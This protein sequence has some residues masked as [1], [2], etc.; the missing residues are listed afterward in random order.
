MRAIAHTLVA[1]AIAGVGLVVAGGSPAGAQ[2]G[3][4]VTSTT[5]NVG[6][7]AAVENFVG[8]PY[9]SGFDGVQAY[10]NY[11]NAKGGV[12]GRKFKLVARLD[13]Q[14]SPSTD[15]VQA[16]SL[17]EE[18]H[19]FAILP[20]VVDNFTAGSY[21]ARSGVPTFGWN[22]NAQWASGYP[23]PGAN[24][25][26]D[27]VVVP[28]ATGTPCSGT[29]APNLFGEK[30]SFL[31]FTCPNAASSYI[32]SQLG[33]KNVAILAYS[34]PQSA[35]CATGTEVGFR[36]YGFNVVVNDHSLPPGFSDIG[37]DIDAMRAGNVKF[38]GSCMDI[39]GNVRAAA[40]LRRAGLTDV[41][42]FAPQGYDPGTLKKY[43]AALNGFI[44]L[45]DFVPFEAANESPGM[46]L[47]LKQMAALGRPVNE[48][49]L[50]GWI[51][52]D[53]LYKG[54]KAAGPNF[55]QASVVQAVNQINGYT[56]DGIRT[57][58]NWSF[59]GHR[60][61]TEGCGA[62]IAVQNGKFVPVFGRPGQPFICSQTNPLP[63]KAD[64]S[65]I[66]FRPPKPGEQLPSTATVP[67]TSPATP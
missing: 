51:D 14:D 61:G 25:P 46:K 27:C 19:V 31:C 7:M 45:S 17:V 47:F 66:Y 59:A 55:T 36:K 33:A 63:D 13:D 52:A 23:T 28:G 30:G 44:F 37:S 4:G 9:G 32:A 49:A 40:A 26:P 41:K 50:A 22:I 2:A 64:S 24:Y 16:R 62:F 18:K 43:G 67:T 21:L 20:V 6:G 15:L 38:V 42:F 57:P 34:V 12:Y 60:P 1:A 54:I 5:I 48:V 53:L 39:G 65:T 56:A 29:G 8:Q 35:A 11:I 10:F 3:P 58:V